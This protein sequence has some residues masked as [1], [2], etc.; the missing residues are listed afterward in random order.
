[1][2]A[3]LRA[4]CAPAPHDVGM[5]LVR[6]APVGRARRRWKMTARFS[7]AAC[8]PDR[9]AIRAAA[10][11]EAAGG[12]AAAVAA[13]EAVAVAA[14]AVAAARTSARVRSVVPVE[15]VRRVQSALPAPTY[16]FA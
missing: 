5:S 11:V 10:A 16:D 9:A 4:C 6:A 3:M 12:A 1:M 8:S 15:C 7:V 13:A 2:N 14:A